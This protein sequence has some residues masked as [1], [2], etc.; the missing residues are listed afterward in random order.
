VEKQREIL[1]IQRLWL[2]EATRNNVLPIDDRLA[3]RMNSDT[4]GRPLLVAGNTQVL[5][6]GMGGL[7]ENGI[8]NV[9]NKSHSITAQLVVPEGVKANGAIFA[10]G[11]IGGGWTL[12]VK[13]GTLTYVYNFLGLRSFVTRA[14]EPLSSGT[15][16]VRME[17]A[18]DGG[19]LAKGGNVT[20]FIDGKSVG[21]GRVEQTQPVVFS[22]DETS[23]VGIK[24]GSPLTAELPPEQSA[25]N[26]RVLAV[27]IEAG[28]ES[29]D[30][31]LSREQV[32]NM[33]V[34]R[35]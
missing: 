20:L 25:F 21:Q 17:F 8:V 30:H 18:Y 28:E 32:L 12:Y 31:L 15:H 3:E 27:V 24:R 9:K 13:D 6:E 34:A 14:T 11:G 10:Q 19:G 5:A 1:P 35:Q 22:A 2:I 26:G 33:I 29:Q 16:Q 7:N 4:A 23:D